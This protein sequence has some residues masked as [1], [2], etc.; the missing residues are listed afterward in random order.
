MALTGCGM[1]HHPYLGTAFAGRMLAVADMT[2]VAERGAHLVTTHAT[3][4][5]FNGGGPATT[6]QKNKLRSLLTDLAVNPEV[7]AIRAYLNYCRICDLE[8]GAVLDRYTVNGAIRALAVS[9]G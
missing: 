9:S 6:A 5:G 2:S 8:D 1:T 4:Q 7:E 3:W